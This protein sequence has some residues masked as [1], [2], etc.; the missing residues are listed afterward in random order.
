MTGHE[1]GARDAVY[2]IRFTAVCVGL[3]FV[4]THLLDG[5][6]MA[7]AH[8]TGSWAV[9]DFL[10]LAWLH[11]LFL[12]FFLVIALVVLACCTLK[13]PDLEFLG[14]MGIREHW[15]PDAFP[16]VEGKTRLFLAIMSLWTVTACSCYRLIDAASHYAAALSGSELHHIA[17][18]LLPGDASPGARIA[19]TALMYFPLFSLGA[20]A[21]MFWLLR[22]DIQR[23]VGRRVLGQGAAAAHEGETRNDASPA[24]AS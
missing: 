23:Q 14:D 24:T 15:A 11:P 5:L 4:L 9:Q 13:F 1:R 18:F 12:T 3:L 20:Y 2:N 17:D 10:Q 21:V 7:A 19:F 16:D 22:I 6:S 8:G